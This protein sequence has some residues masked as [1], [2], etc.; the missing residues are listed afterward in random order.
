MPQNLYGRGTIDLMP[1]WPAESTHWQVTATDGTVTYVPLDRDS[2]AAALAVLGLQRRH[3]G[4]K[5]LHYMRDG[6]DAGDPWGSGMMLAG[7]CADALTIMGEGTTAPGLGYAPAPGLES[8][9]LDEVAADSDSYGELAY[10]AA[11]VLDGTFTA[12]DLQL[13]CRILDRYLDIVRAAGRDY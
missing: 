5:V 1:P 6:W 8:V 7:A 2:Y 11:L 10:V 13:A 4:S 12:A 3:R 9:T